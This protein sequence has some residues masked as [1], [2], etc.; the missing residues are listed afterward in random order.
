MLISIDRRFT[1]VNCGIIEARNWLHI[2]LNEHPFTNVENALELDDY[3]FNRIYGIKKPLKS[4]EI[5]FYC[6]AGIRSDSAAQI[7]YEKVSSFSS[8]H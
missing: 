1:E 8:K 4:D 3:D 7:F 2:P 5:I 6:M